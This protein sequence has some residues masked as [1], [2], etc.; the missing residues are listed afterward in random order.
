MAKVTNKSTD[1]QCCF[2][3]KKFKREETILTHKCTKRDRYNDRDSR[4]MREAF[5]IYMH[6]MNF[7]RM[8][9]K[10]GVEPLMHFIKSKYFNEFFDLAGYILQTDILNKED[11]ITNIISTGKKVYEW[12]TTKT[13]TE[14]TIQCIKNEHPTYAVERSIPALVEWGALNE[15]EWNT[16]FSNV[17]TERA[18]RWLETGKISPWLIYTASTESGNKLLSRFSDTELDYI[19]Q[20]IEPTFFTR[21]M[22]KYDDECKR[23]RELLTG[24]GL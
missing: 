1:F 18:I 23:I 15:C 19:Y 22:I 16:F 7:N 11:F 3:D 14:W 17:S 5:R 4:Q 6:F 2:C 24:A 21:K 20:Y 9:I 12:T 13:L 10:K 8:S